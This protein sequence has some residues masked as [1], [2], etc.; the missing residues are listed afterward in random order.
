VP[1]AVKE[2]AMPKRAV[3]PAYRRLE[4]TVEQ[5]AA[6]VERS[7]GVPNKDLARLADQLRSLMDKFER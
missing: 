6:L 5:L 1:R 2:K 4:D 3:S 7:K